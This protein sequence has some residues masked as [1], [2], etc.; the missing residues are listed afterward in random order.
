MCR[1]FFSILHFT[2]SGKK[3][4]SRDQHI[5]DA[6]ENA[7]QMVY[8]FLFWK[9]PNDSKKEMLFVLCHSV[10]SPVT[11]FVFARILVGS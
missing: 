2:Q 7:H 4:R 1:V 11:L 5:L 10:T 9:L 3:Q 8:N 6:I